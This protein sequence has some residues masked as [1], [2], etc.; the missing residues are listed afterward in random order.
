V[1]T[2]AGFVGLTG[3]DGFTGGEGAGWGGEVSLVLV[4]DFDAFDSIDE[5]REVKL[6]VEAETEVLST[7][8]M[9][10]ASV[11]VT[12]ECELPLKQSSHTRCF[13]V[14]WIFAKIFRFVE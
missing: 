5:K 3:F 11:R 7:D 9:S 4:E 13:T 12:D 2:L 10:A 14:A 6:P 1:L 8:V